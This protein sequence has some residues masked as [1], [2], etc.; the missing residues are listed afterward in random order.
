MVKETLLFFV[1]KSEV[2][3]VANKYVKRRIDPDFISEPCY[4]TK[5]SRFD[6]RIDYMQEVDDGR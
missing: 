4:A 1:F 3:G 2:V 5:S 6:Y